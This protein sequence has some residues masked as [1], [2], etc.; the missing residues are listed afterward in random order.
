MLPF[1]IYFDE[2]EGNIQYRVVGAAQSISAPTDLPYIGLITYSEE[3]FVKAVIPRMEE[4]IGTE[5]HDQLL[6]QYAIAQAEE[7]D[8]YEKLVKKVTRVLSEGNKTAS[9]IGGR[10]RVRIAVVSK[11]LA[12]MYREKQA[13]DI[14]PQHGSHTMTWRLT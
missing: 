5:F 4:I 7:R 8:F 13:T 1:K 11:C 6:E 3:H 9:E 14:H 12:A 10:L 2:K